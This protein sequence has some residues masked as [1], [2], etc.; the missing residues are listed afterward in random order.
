[1]LR[2]PKGTVLVAPEDLMTIPVGSVIYVGKKIDLT[3]HWDES[4][5]GSDW[6]VF[7]EGKAMV[8]DLHYPDSETEDLDW[9]KP[10]QVI[11]V[12]RNE[13]YILA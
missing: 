3:S 6:F 9:F 4:E 1:M 8:I 2:M 10:W 12:G 5:D 13:E 11:I 7:T